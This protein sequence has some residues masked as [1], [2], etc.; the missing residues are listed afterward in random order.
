MNEIVPMGQNERGDETHPAFGLIGT[1][2]GSVITNGRGGATLFDS[3]IQHQH[4]VT[5]RINTAV[6]KRDLHHD[7]IHAEDQIVE[8]QLSEAQWASFVSSMNIGDGVPCT[9]T[10][11]GYESVPSIPFEP[12]LAKTMKETHEAADGA[13]DSIKDAMEAYQ[14]CLDRKAPAKERNDALRMLHSSINNAVPN[15]DY[16]GKVLVEHAEDV[17]QKS[18]AD[19]EAY[20]VAKA[21]QLGVDVSELGG[22]GEKD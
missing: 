15:V 19:V 9:I 10:R 4:I 2:R 3:D 22:S 6:R 17:V 16:A 1:S 21:R 13:F 11:R 18:H 7:W 12:R 20:V 5:I 8:V 14:E